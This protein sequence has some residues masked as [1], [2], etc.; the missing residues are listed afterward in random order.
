MCH[1][2]KIINC[3]PG[4]LH[5]SR[6]FPF[7]DS[8]VPDVAKYAKAEQILEELSGMLS[9]HAGLV[10]CGEKLGVSYLKETEV[11]LLLKKH[12]PDWSSVGNFDVYWSLA[13]EELETK[14]SDRPITIRTRGTER[15]FY[16]TAPHHP[17]F[18]RITKALYSL[19]AV[20]RVPFMLFLLL[21][22]C[23]YWAIN[24]YKKAQL[25]KER[26]RQWT[27]AVLS[28]L[29]EQEERFRR[30]EEERSAV[31]VSQ[32]RDFFLADV[33]SLMDRERL[34]KDVRLPYYNVF[35]S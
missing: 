22:S 3:F 18:C 14:R 30:G 26:I 31:S 16:S 10:E 32:L 33:K 23:L 28:V 13:V 1:Q 19:L 35:M 11:K 34:W 29:V 15:T 27:E 21:S 5:Q 9:E 24:T 2:N 6:T 12:N 20:Y 8:C 17:F 7:H 25:H 4:F